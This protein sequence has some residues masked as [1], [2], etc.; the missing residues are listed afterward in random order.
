MQDQ[1]RLLREQRQFQADLERRREADK[2]LLRAL[3]REK[4]AE[5]RAMAAVLKILANTQHQENAHSSAGAS[6]DNQ[7]A[8]EEE[9]SS[10]DDDAVVESVS[11]TPNKPEIK[12][13]SQRRCSDAG[14]HEEAS[15]TSSRK[16]PLDTQD[17]VTGSTSKRETSTRSASPTNKLSDEHEN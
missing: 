2:D 17:T 14:T 11:P 13:G 12:A 3:E 8:A 4:E 5:V 7:I 9:A 1:E 16:T 15:H 6:L 10:G